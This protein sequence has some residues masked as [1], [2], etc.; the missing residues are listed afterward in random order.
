MSLTESAIFRKGDSLFPILDLARDLPFED[1]VHFLLILCPP[2]SYIIKGIGLEQI[3]EKYILCIS[4]LIES[5]I[6]R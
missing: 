3:T 6:D 2:E 1:E 5:S 4:S